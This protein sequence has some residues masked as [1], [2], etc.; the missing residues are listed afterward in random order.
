MKN[1]SRKGQ[2][3]QCGT[4]CNET[5]RSCWVRTMEWKGLWLRTCAKR[6]WRHFFRVLNSLPPSP[7]PPPPSAAPSFILGLVSLAPCFH[8]HVLSLLW[9]EM[10]CSSRFWHVS[11]RGRPPSSPPWWQGSCLVGSW[12]RGQRCCRE[13]DCSLSF[14]SHYQMGLCNVS[15]KTIMKIWISVKVFL[16]VSLNCDI[17]S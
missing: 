17:R 12:G 8:C 4:R 16:F 14:Q 1:P 10:A 11:A 3:W 9:L 15:I 6:V 7:P 13:D 2:V 5:Y